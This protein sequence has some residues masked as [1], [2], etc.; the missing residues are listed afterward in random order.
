MTHTF[1]GLTF[2]T[3]GISGVLSGLS[4]VGGGLLLVPVSSKANNL[5]DIVKNL[6]T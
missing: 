4:G 2:A 3:G 1:D 5:S 6:E